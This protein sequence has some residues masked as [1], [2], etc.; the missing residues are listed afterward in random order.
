M[1]QLKILDKNRTWLQLESI[2]VNIDSL[3]SKCR[4]AIN[5]F[6][7]LNCKKNIMSCLGNDASLHSPNQISSPNGAYH[8]VMQDDGNFVLYSTPS[9]K[10]L[11][12][13]NTNGKGQGP[14]RVTMQ[15]DGNLVIYETCGKPTWSSN[16]Y[17]KGTK[18]YQ[19]VMQDDGNLVIYDCNR[20]AT[21]ATDPLRH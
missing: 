12:A 13:S 4:T 3:Y 7:L 16:T 20:H 14:F 1:I 21:W 15:D 6:I 2:L 5:C 18:P 9:R 17:Y 10:P 19:L 11:W 8:A